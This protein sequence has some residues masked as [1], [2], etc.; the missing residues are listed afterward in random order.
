MCPRFR[1]YQILMQQLIFLL[2]SGKHFRV[3]KKKRGIEFLLKIEKSLLRK[4]ERKGHCV[5][6]KLVATFH[7]CDCFL[8]SD[9]N[10]VP[11]YKWNLFAF[12]RFSATE[13]VPEICCILLQH[14]Y[15]KKTSLVK[16]T[17]DIVIWEILKIMLTGWGK[18]PLVLKRAMHLCIPENAGR[19][20][21]DRQLGQTKFV[22]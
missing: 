6:W 18:L 12:R 3:Q 9:A 1:I 7:Q 2:K 17:H 13:P 20:L 10:K 21:T 4:R 5:L 8:E 14:C 15:R 19:N 16:Y 11:T 22:I